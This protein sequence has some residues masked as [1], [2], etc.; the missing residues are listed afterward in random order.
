MNDLIVS[1]EVPGQP[2]GK[3]R[4][5]FTRTGHAYTP[6][7]TVQYEALIAARYW[8]AL[9]SQRQTLTEKAKAA[10]VEIEILALYAVPKSDSKVM[11]GRKLSGQILPRAK[12]DIDNV[13]KAV[14]DALND[15]AYRDDSQVVRLTVSK[16]YSDNPG[17]LCTVTHKD[18]VE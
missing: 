2:Q 8:K 10:D 7:K 9:N 13:A 18:C 6:E 4:P 14:L 1:F 15:F 12:P 11:Q 5:R 3:G 17:L 16:K